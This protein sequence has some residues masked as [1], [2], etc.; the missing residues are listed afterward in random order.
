MKTVRHILLSFLCMAT[1]MTAAQTND[2]TMNL[3]FPAE[4]TSPANNTGDVK[5]SMLK[6]SGNTM[7]T[8]FLFSPGSRNYWHYHPGIV[9]TLLVLDGEGWYQEDGTPKKHIK[10]GDVVVTPADVKHWNGATSDKSLV[11]I[12]VTESGVDGHVVQLR[13]VTEEEYIK[14]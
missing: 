14:E 8:H 9:Q 5:L 11:C 4:H 3:I 7:I 13:P 10:K 12:T 6:D 2:K 1:F